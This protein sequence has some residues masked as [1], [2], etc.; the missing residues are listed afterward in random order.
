MSDAETIILKPRVLDLG[1]FQVRRVLPGHPIQMV[2]PFIF[3]D[4]IGPSTFAA[5]SG[6]DVR[7]HPHIGLATVTYLF[8]GS[9]LHRDS[10]GS[11]QEIRPGDVN[12]MTAG[13]GIAHSE[14]TPAEQRPAGP[15][16]HGIQTWVALPKAAE[17]T[18]PAFAHHPAAALPELQR[19][20][21]K[22]RVIAGKAFGA[23]SPVETQSA[24]L[25]CALEFA[26]GARIA[27]PA[28]HAERAVYLVDGELTV[29]GNP[30]E[31]QNLAV[32][33]AKKTVDLASGSGAR[34]LLLGGEP[35]DGPR[36]ISWN[37]VSSSKDRIEQA[38]ADWKAQRFD[39]V[40]GE[41]ERIPLPEN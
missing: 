21:V 5:G 26:P 38:R 1:G 31:P 12:W 30:L 25:Y 39:P 28:E 23:L 7:P 8:Q 41:T 33:P 16:L 29:A 15:L 36:F 22:L 40:P 32:L 27:V 17:E 24:V 19:D 34:V 6:V 14:R 4:H 18:V 11:V 3:F 13:R 37:F 10:L 2:G 35:M 9:L 20:G